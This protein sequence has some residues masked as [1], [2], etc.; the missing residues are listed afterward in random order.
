SISAKPT[1][2]CA[3]PPACI[4][5]PAMMNKGKASRTREFKERKPCNIK[6]F[7]LTSYTSV[8]ISSVPAKDKATGTPIPSR[9]RSKRTENPACIIN[10]LHGAKPLKTDKHRAKH[11]SGYR[12]RAD[13]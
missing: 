11:R 3:I 7:K 10:G 5:Y 4:K 12:R 2:R 13:Q 6:L 1:K 9:N 8:N